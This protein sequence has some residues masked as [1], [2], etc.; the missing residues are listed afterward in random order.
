MKVIHQ[1]FLDIGLKPLKERKGWLEN[2]EINKKLNPEYEH[3]LWDDK[4][5]KVFIDENYPEMWDL[6]NS[7]PTKFYLIDFVRYLILKKMGGV[8]IDMDVRCKKPLPDC[9]ILIGGNYQN[10]LINNNLMKFPPKIA[11]N[12]LDFAIQSYNRI[13]EKGLYKNWR[14]RHLYWSVGFRM[15]GQFCK[16][17]GLKSEIDFREYFYDECA[18]SYIGGKEGVIQKNYLNKKGENKIIEGHYL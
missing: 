13:Q 10:D 6:I 11:S 12:L 18:R 8:Y 4:K 17:R 7:F 15:L 3:I 14:G 2:V 1:I 16:R 5:V 9:E